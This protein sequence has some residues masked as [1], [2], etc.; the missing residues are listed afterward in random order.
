MQAAQ[1]AANAVP[2]VQYLRAHGHPSMPIVFVEGT[3][4]G[5]EWLV[6]DQEALAEADDAA[7]YAA[8]Q[9]LLAAGD[10][11][12][13][14]VRTTEL[15][16]AFDQLDSPTSRGLHPTDRGM[17]DIADFYIGYLPTIAPVLAGTTRSQ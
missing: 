4:M 1:I 13:H 10:R 15:F 7:L 8:Y 9:Q 17:A 16:S 3:Q 14:Y 2:L 12:M 11:N 6:P 5:Y